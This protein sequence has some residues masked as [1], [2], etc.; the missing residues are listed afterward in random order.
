MGAVLYIYIYFFRGGRTIWRNQYYK[1]THHDDKFT[2]EI[3]QLINQLINL[4]KSSVVTSIF[5]L[6]ILYRRSKYDQY[7]VISII[8][9]YSYWYF[10]ILI[11]LIT[12]V[13]GTENTKLINSNIA[14]FQQM[15]HY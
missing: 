12:R 4:S 15:N 11:I 3:N 14:D 7:E 5:I 10:L 8:W 2:E 9:G 13:T 1:I 6:N